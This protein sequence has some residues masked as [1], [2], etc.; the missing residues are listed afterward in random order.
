MLM[1][2]RTELSVRN[3]RILCHVGAFALG[4]AMSAGP[5]CAQVPVGGE[6][7]APGV[8]AGDV[9][10]VWVWRE[11][12][13]SGEFPVNARGRVVLPLLGELQVAGVGADVLSDSLRV[14]LRQ[15]ITNPSIDVTVL[16]RISVQGQVV[17][18]G[19][20]TVD[21]TFNIAAVIALAGGASASGDAGKVRLRRGSQVILKRLDAA[22]VVERSPVQSGDE[23]YVPQR[24][25]LARNGSMILWILASSAATVAVTLALR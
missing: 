16:R 25:F 20:Y 21:A 18:P 15:F 22:A 7:S 6:A 13:L 14:L 5:L 2:D 1:P 23:I 9:I 4:L 10:R 24:G 11:K 12:D 19:F 3:R 8:R 17:K